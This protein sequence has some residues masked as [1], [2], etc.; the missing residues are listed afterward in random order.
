[1]FKLTRI[2]TII[3]ALSLSAGAWANNEST[4]AKLKRIGKLNVVFKLDFIVP[5]DLGTI[6]DNYICLEG[7]VIGKGPLKNEIDGSV[8]NCLVT[9]VGHLKPDGSLFGE[10]DWRLYWLGNNGF[11]YR[12]IVNG[13][14]ELNPEEAAKL[15]SGAGVLK[16]NG[17]RGIYTGEFHTNDPNLLSL[18]NQAVLLELRQAELDENGNLVEEYSILIIDEDRNLFSNNN[19]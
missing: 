10:V 3:I 9:D 12:F 19:N 16:D 8:Q 1:M 13:T 6:I 11:Q 14:V 2:I 15:F 17:L 7:T 5:S 18:N 4:S